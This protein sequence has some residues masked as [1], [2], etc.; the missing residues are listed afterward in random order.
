M[1]IILVCQVRAIA[2]ARLDGATFYDSLDETITINPQNEKRITKH[3]IPS[4]EIVRLLS[5]IRVRNPKFLPPLPPSIWVWDPSVTL[6]LI[7]RLPS[8]PPPLPLPPSLFSFL[9]SLHIFSF[10]HT[11]TTSKEITKLGQKKDRDWRA[12]LK[13]LHQQKSAKV[14][15]SIPPIRRLFFCLDFFFLFPGG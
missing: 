15:W 12:F 14:L 10:T 5:M 1:S 8:S 13:S 7:S 9:D 4:Q 11:P 2:R 3:V 6:L